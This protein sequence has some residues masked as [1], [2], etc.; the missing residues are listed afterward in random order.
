MHFS[1]QLLDFP[2]AVLHSSIP[3]KRLRRI[4]PELADPPVQR[5]L[6]QPEIAGNL[7]LRPI[8]AQRRPHCLNL[9][10][11]IEASSL[12]SHRTPPAGKPAS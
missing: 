6:V 1:P 11:P 12:L 9:V 5:L 3:R 4:V 2:V 8:S 7:V 10:R